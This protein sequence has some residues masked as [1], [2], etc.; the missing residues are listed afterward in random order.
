MDRHPGGRGGG[1]GVAKRNSLAMAW[2]WVI[3]KQT[4]IFGSLFTNT[5]CFYCIFDLTA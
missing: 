5:V 2:A 4:V 3:Q 1:G